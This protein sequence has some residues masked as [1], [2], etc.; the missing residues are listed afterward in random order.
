MSIHHSDI[1]QEAL[2]IESY[3]LGFLAHK[4]DTYASKDNDEFDHDALSDIAFLD[5]MESRGVRR[6]SSSFK[7]YMIAYAIGYTDSMTKQPCR[8]SMKSVGQSGYVKYWK[9]YGYSGLE[10]GL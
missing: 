4:L 3:S 5:L 6:K 1:R 2:F 9:D 10:M 8:I 7:F